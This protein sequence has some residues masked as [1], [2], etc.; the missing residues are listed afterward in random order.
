MRQCSR[1]RRRHGAAFYRPI[2]RSELHQRVDRQVHFTGRLYSGTFRGDAGDRTR[3]SSGHRCRDPAPA[4]RGDAQG[5][6]RPFPRPPRGGCTPLRRPV[7]AN[8]GILSRVL[9]GGIP[10]PEYDGVPDST[11]K[12]PG[13]GADHPRLYHAYRTA[14]AWARSGAAHAAAA[15]RRV[16][17]PSRRRRQVPAFTEPAIKIF[18]LVIERKKGTTRSQADAA[19][20]DSKHLSLIDQAVA[21]R[22]WWCDAAP[23]SLQSCSAAPPL[24]A[25]PKHG[26]PWRSNRLHVSRRHPPHPLSSTRRGRR[27]TALLRTTSSWSRRCWAPSWLTTRRSTG[28]PTFSSHGISSSLFIRSFTR[29][30][31]AS[32]V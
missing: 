4:L 3:R 7:C 22:R 2:E 1:R 18:S 29:S 28:F 15:G 5:V 8:V 30:P 10:T 21:H 14:P 13:H 9:G 24:H 6:A 16:S 19:N 25:K 32:C 11:C 23:D 17:P 26:T 31:Q 27:L 12:A 20:C